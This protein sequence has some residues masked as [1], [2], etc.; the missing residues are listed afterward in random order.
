MDNLVLSGMLSLKKEGN[1]YTLSEAYGLL[2]KTVLSITLDYF[3][4]LQFLAKCLDYDKS[5]LGKGSTLKTNNVSISHTP[6]GEYSI[7]IDEFVSLVEFSKEDME[8]LMKCLKA[9]E[10]WKE[11]NL[12]LSYGLKENDFYN[13][14]IRDGEHF[15]KYIPSFR[16]VY[17]GLAV[18]KDGQVRIYELNS[19]GYWTSELKVE[20]TDGIEHIKRAFYMLQDSMNWQTPIKI[21]SHCG[22]INY[23]PREYQDAEVTM[24]NKKQCLNK[25]D[26]SE[27]IQVINML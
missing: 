27:I 18:E 4:D 15:P 16:K 23:D 12:A 22:V 6:T 2:S 17:Y 21:V 13:G 7:G 5:K 14:T 10:E 25:E 19:S 11:T 9:S 3:G 26:V 1:K 20:N 8:D 24:G